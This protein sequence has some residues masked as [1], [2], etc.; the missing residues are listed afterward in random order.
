M[1][2]LEEFLNAPDGHEI[3]VRLWRPEPC[4]QLLV[5]SHGMAEYCERYAPLAEFLTEQN[6]AVL[7][8]NHRGHGMDCPDDDLGHYADDQGWQ[9]VID[10]LHQAIE[11]GRKEIPNVKVSLLGHSMGSFISQAYIQQYG[12]HLEHLILSATNRI[13]RP[14]LHASNLLISAIKAF[15]GKRSTSTFVTQTAFAP[16]NAKFKPNRTE[17]DWISRD[18]AIVDEYIADPFCGFDCTLGL[19]TDFISGMLAI[20]PKSWPND[21]KLHLLSGTSDPVGDMGKGVKLLAEQLKQSEKNLQSVK[22]YPQARHEIINE[23]NRDEVWQDILTILKTG[24]TD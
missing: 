5:I 9:K 21:V 23:S 19:W 12:Q 17:F 4:E 6:I 16:F 10:D 3:P 14:K 20:Q 18:D 8:I 2:Y 15:K 24:K 22:L 7:A 11:Y 1:Q 13:D